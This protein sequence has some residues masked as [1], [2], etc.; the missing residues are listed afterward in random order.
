MSELFPSIR[1]FIESRQKCFFCD[2]NLKCRLS[3]FIG[4]RESGMPLLNSPLEK[5]RFIFDISRTS[6]SYTVEALGTLDIQNNKLIFDMKG[7]LAHNVI[8]HKN[9]LGEWRTVAVDNMVV[10]EAFIDL[11][12]YIQQYCPKRNCLQKYTIA[13][14]TLRASSLENGWFI[15]PISTYYESFK[16]GKLLVMNDYAHSNTSIFSMVKESAEPLVVPLMDLGAMG[17]RKALTR[18]HTLITFS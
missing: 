17:K 12:P 6:P 9:N 10:K 4:I 15:H 13:S 8:L 16:T 7:E 5:D 11:R 18:V 3:N 14:S 1:Y 2:A